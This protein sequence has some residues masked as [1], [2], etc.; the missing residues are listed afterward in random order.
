MYEQ[1]TIVADG[2]FVILHARFSNFG[3]PV[4][5]IVVDILRI[6]DRILDEH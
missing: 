3:Q 2:D 1:G 5:C 6:K 4:N